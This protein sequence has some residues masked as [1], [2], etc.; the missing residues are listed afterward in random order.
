MNVTVEIISLRVDV[1]PVDLALM[2][3]VEK[4]QRALML[5]KYTHTPEYMHTIRPPVS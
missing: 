5:A 4:Q 2:D 3:L 1:L